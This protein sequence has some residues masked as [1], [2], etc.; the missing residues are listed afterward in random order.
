MSCLSWLRRPCEVPIDV[1]KLHDEGKSSTDSSDINVRSSAV[2]PGGLA[3]IKSR[4]KELGHYMNEPNIPDT[5]FSPTST[6]MPSWT[7]V[8]SHEGQSEAGVAAEFCNDRGHSG[9]VTPSQKIQLQTLKVVFFNHS[10]APP[11][12]VNLRALLT[13]AAGRR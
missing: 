5:A 8:G 1:F 3:G 4:M 9:N 2:I 11:L 13:F 10:D 12:C 6:N 7:S